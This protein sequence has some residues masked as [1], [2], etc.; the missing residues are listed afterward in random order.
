MG[1]SPTHV[2][3]AAVRLEPIKALPEM[4]GADAFAGLPP[5]VVTTDVAAEVAVVLPCLL[6]A[7]T[8]NRSRKPRSCCETTYDVVVA[9][10]RLAAE[11]LVLVRDRLQPGP[12]PG[13]AGDRTP[14]DR[15]AGDRRRRDLRGPDL[16]TRCSARNDDECT[17]DGD[18]RPS[19]KSETSR[20]HAVLFGEC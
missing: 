9:R 15:D 14:G 4:V 19:N 6:L 2:P 18:Q 3:V 1:W 12:G 13:G 8:R 20:P 17:G 7:V 5:S 11:P 10:V 16:L